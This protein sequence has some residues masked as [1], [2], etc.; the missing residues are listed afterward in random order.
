MSLSFKYGFELTRRLLDVELRKLES[1]PDP[2]EETTVH[3]A[4]LWTQPSDHLLT[5]FDHLLE[6]VKELLDHEYN[7]VYI[8]G[9]YSLFECPI[10]GYAFVL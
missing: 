8:G 6:K 4:S 1:H 2:A 3:D 10:F 7:G 5:A 9:S